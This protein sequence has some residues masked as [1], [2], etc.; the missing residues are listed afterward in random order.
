MIRYNR[1]QCDKSAFFPS[2]AIKKTNIRVINP[3]PRRTRQALFPP[4]F[5]LFWIIIRATFSK[6]LSSPPFLIGDCAALLSHYCRPHPLQ[7]SA[8][9]IWHKILL[10]SW[11]VRGVGGWWWGL[12]GAGGHLWVGRTFFSKTPFIDFW[13]RG[14]HD[15]D[16]GFISGPRH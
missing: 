8:R 1:I 11:K 6:W 2:H 12:G 3:K 9:S 10:R 7:K 16:F 14:K 5:F 13:N 4:L 15:I